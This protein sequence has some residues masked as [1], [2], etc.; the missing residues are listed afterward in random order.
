MTDR[1]KIITFPYYY[2]MWGS[3]SPIDL[4]RPDYEFIIST[5]ARL[6]FESGFHYVFRLFCCCLIIIIWNSG[7]LTQTGAFIF[8]IPRSS[9]RWHMA[10]PFVDRWQLRLLIVLERG[11][12]PRAPF[13]FG[14]LNLH[15]LFLGTVCLWS[16]TRELSN[17]TSSD[18]PRWRDMDAWIERSWL[19]SQIL[20]HSLGRLVYYCLLKNYGAMAFLP[21]MMCRLSHAWTIPRQILHRFMSD[22]YHTSRYWSVLSHFSPLW[23]CVSLFRRSDVS[24]FCVLLWYPTF[25]SKYNC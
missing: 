22:R 6:R 24:A 1:L 5:P 19:L 3:K 12:C 2:W 4:N 8:V 7:M 23:S 18:A 21:M 14:W 20:T 9:S 11:M 16:L 15:G 10:I 17:N 25:E 13:P